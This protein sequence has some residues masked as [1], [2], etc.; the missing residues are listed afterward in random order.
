MELKYWIC[1]RLTMKKI[2]VLG[3]LFLSTVA[4]ADGPCDQLKFKAMNIASKLTGKFY[5]C[6]LTR[7]ISYFPDFTHKWH[8][9]YKCT[10]TIGTESGLTIKFVTKTKSKEEPYVQSVSVDTFGDLKLPVTE[11][12]P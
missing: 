1:E 7:G 8:H 6:E 11:Y 10:E 2:F 12:Y 4:L 5:S 9:A 3:S